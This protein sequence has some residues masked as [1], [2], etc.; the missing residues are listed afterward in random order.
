MTFEELGIKSTFL[1]RPNFPE[2]ESYLD[3]QC[4]GIL[5]P[6]Q[7]GD[8]VYLIDTYHI[9]S[10]YGN[11]EAFINKRKEN[12]I[13][14]NIP[15]VFDYYYKHYYKIKSKEDLKNRF[16]FEIDLDEYEPCRSD[17]FNDYKSEDKC[18]N[19]ALWHECNY[20]QGGY[21]LVKKG[22][23][24]DISL[25]VENL[26]NNIMYN[27]YAPRVNNNRDKEKLDKLIREN[28]DSEYDRERYERVSE[29]ISYLEGVEKDANEKY[30][31]IFIRKDEL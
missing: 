24:K 20:H 12:T 27:N 15:Y 31:K 16:T 9:S 18:S 3:N 25:V 30:N 21:Y 2:R 8:A 28:P 22:A 13:Y 14:K 23:Q 29:W 7:V 5:L 19:V 4:Y 17:D 1:Y 26:M 11:Y 6:F 10:H